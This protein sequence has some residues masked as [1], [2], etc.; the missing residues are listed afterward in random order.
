MNAR[1]LACG[2]ILSADVVTL[3]RRGQIRVL[4]DGQF[5]LVDLAC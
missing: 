2:C 3:S 5:V 1:D 4:V